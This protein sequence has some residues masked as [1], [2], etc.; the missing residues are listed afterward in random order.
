M[1]QYTTLFLGDFVVQDETEE[2]VSEALHVLREWNPEWKPANFMTDFSVVEIHSI[3]SVF[4][5]VGTSVFLCDFHRE[6]AWE[7]WTK[8]SEH[9]LTSE[10]REKLLHLLRSMA[11][12]PWISNTE[13]P[14]TNVAEA[15]KKL[16]DSDVYKNNAQVQRWLEG[17]WF[18]EEKRWARA[19]R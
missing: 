17:T 9:G 16:V 7:R 5:D 6:Q 19:Y 15:K 13:S 14:F 1:K 18:P 10:D 8:K 2:Q 3:E 4:Q 11:Y 12:A